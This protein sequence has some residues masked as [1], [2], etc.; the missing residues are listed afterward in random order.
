MNNTKLIQLLATLSTRE[1]TRFGQYVH[2]PFFNR[3]KKLIALFEWLKVFAPDFFHPQCNRQEA[4][5]AMYPNR[6][7]DELR[8]N[9][10]IANLYRLLLQFLAYLEYEKQP[11]IAHDLLFEALH[12]RSAHKQLST[13]A[14]RIQQL[15]NKKSTESYEY[16]LAKSALNRQLDRIA[17]QGQER[18]YTD[19]LQKESDNLDVF[20]GINKLRL[21]CEMASRRVVIQAGYD[22][23]YIAFIKQQYPE[24]Y[25]APVLQVYLKALEMLENR[26][27]ED[28]FFELKNLLE[29]HAHLLPKE[30]LSTLYH[31]A[32][33]FCISKINSGAAA[34]YRQIFQLYELMLQQELLFDRGY[35]SQ[36]AFKNIVTTSIRLGEY[37]W[38][39]NFITTYQTYLPE[40][41]KANAVAY[42]TAAMWYARKDYAQALFCLQEVE[43]TDSSYHLGVKIIQ[44]KCYYELE[45]AEAYYALLEAFKKYIRRNKSLSDYRIKANSNFLLLARRLYQLKEKKSLMAD[46]GYKKQWDQLRQRLEAAHPIANKEWLVKVLSDLEI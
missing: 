2:S 36:F 22:P 14:N 9:N 41:T 33:N 38:V 43:F 32:L 31:Y 28:H 19:H 37:Q 17:L 5:R 13:N 3:H 21:A 12:Q 15:L 42:N 20:Y 26:D 27:V 24:Q 4:W 35:I 10:F 30:E 16:F 7:Y 45:E 6:R 8:L 1:R 46:S 34:F 18:K 39:E 44:L 11:L 25:H 40:H 23:R 29:V